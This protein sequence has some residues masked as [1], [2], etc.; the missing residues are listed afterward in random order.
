MNIKSFIAD[1]K[2][3]LKSALTKLDNLYSSKEEGEKNLAE[4]R[5]DIVDVQKILSA[6]R[7]Y[8]V[9]LILQGM[10]T[11][12]KDGVVRHVFSGVNPQGVRVVSFKKPS[13]EELAHDYLWR[14]QLRLPERG[15]N[16]G[17]KS[18]R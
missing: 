5:D 8:S 12:G 3:S 15:V 14:C 6:D 1:K 13:D 16:R 18:G 4:I 9:L 7:R 11:S 10:D 2:V 17:G